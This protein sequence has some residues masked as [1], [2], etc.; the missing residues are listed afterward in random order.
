MA[1]NQ[2]MEVNVLGDLEEMP[3]QNKNASDTNTNP[4]ESPSNI[5]S[6]SHQA[7]KDPEM[8]TKKNI[9]IQELM[10]ELEDSIAAETKRYKGCVYVLWVVAIIFLLIWIVGLPL[11]ISYS[12]DWTY[13]AAW[14]FSIQAGFGVGYGALSVQ[15]QGM[16]LFLILHLCLGAISISFLIAHLIS[17]MIDANDKK[18]KSKRT[19]TAEEL[20]QPV[21]GYKS[22]IVGSVLLIGVMVA[23]V[24]YGI[25]YEKWNFTESL[26]F[27]VSTSTL[28]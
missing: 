6:P 8:N 10:Q 21:V 17:R 18:K 23:G 2:G 25:L 3:E 24:L 12:E 5:K 27:I 19:I 28:R 16:E 20:G 26:Y 22:W 4:G 11:A 9:N 14:Y 1:T 15:T 7:D 13:A